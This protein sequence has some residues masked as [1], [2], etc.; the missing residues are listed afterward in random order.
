VCPNKCVFFS[1]K[2][3]KS[4]FVEVVNE[5]GEKMTTEVVISCFVTCLSHLG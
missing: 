5:D 3:C 4:R 1:G 2:S